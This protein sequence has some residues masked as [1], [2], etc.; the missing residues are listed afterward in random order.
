C[1][2]TS[3]RRGIWG[4]LQT[5]WVWEKY[6]PQSCATYGFVNKAIQ[7]PLRFSSQ[8]RVDHPT[9]CASF[10]REHRDALGRLL[11]GQQC[12]Q[13]LL[14]G[15]YGLFHL[16]PVVMPLIRAHDAGLGAGEVIEQH[17]YDF[18]P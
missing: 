3:T 17:L 15:V 5:L 18:D 11:A 8:L 9:S 1:L 10:L 4:A 13:E 16:L 2:S 6:R 14:V 12:Y 7:E